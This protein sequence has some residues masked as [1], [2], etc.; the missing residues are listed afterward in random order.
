[1][2]KEWR[3]SDSDYNSDGEWSLPETKPDEN[4]NDSLHHPTYKYY[5]NSEGFNV[6][7]PSPVETR[8]CQNEYPDNDNHH[9]YRQDFWRFYNDFD[10]PP[11]RQLGVEILTRLRST[12]GGIYYTKGNRFKQLHYV[13]RKLIYICELV[14]SHLV[15]S[16]ESNHLS[17]EVDKSLI[18]GEALDL[19]GYSYAQTGTEKISITGDL[20]LVCKNSC[21]SASCPLAES[22]TTR[23]K[24]KSWSIFPIR[25]STGI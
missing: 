19:L 18:Q 14:P 16:S 2:V 7:T 17:T 21:R 6:P 24:L 20:E 22:Y 23:A 15:P 3:S 25:P 11:N 12:K 10:P 9:P 13:D 8:H 1:M 4:N 5:I